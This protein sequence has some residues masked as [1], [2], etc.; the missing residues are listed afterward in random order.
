MYETGQTKIK[1][2]TFWQRCIK[3]TQGARGIRRIA[4]CLVVQLSLTTI[5]S[6]LT[7]FSPQLFNLI[8]A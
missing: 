4:L 2:K 7:L 6:A 8:A 1:A 3:L 5:S